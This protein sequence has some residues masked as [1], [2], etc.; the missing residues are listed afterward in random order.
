[1]RKEDPRIVFGWN[2]KCIENKTVYKNGVKDIYEKY[3]CDVKV[4][5]RYSKLISIETNFLKDKVLI[6]LQNVL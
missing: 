3:H 1:M 5:E 6:H 4:L 2:K